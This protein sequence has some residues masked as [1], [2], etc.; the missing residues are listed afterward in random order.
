MKWITL[1][2]KI[3]KQPLKT[4]QHADVYAILENPKTHEWEHVPLLLKF[5][6]SGKPYLV[7]DFKE[8]KPSNPHKKTN[9]NN[10]SE[11]LV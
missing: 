11:P 2:N 7:R 5:D 3:G 10:I 6:A 9:K 1:F 4:T 8:K